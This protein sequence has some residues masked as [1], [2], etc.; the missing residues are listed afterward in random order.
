MQRWA[1]GGEKATQQRNRQGAGIADGGGP[2]QL[3]LGGHCCG[4]SINVRVRGRLREKG[5]WQRREKGGME[6]NI[7]KLEGKGKSGRRGM[8]KQMYVVQVS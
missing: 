3:G 8:A 6:G 5:I 4:W 1:V 7:K 2:G